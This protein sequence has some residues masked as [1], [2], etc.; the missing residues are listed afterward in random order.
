MEPATV[1]ELE[2]LDHQDQVLPVLHK[3]HAS[4]EK[5]FWRWQY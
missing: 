5:A 3:N 2:L 1:I 4:S